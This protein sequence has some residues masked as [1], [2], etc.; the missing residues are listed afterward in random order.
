LL[1][2]RKNV[3][4]ESVI[5]LLCGL[6]FLIFGQTFAYG[7]ACVWIGATGTRL[8]VLDIV[9]LIQSARD[10]GTILQ[11]FGLLV[12][13]YI[14]ASRTL[15]VDKRFRT[16]L[17]FS[18]VTALSIMLAFASSVVLIPV[19]KANLIAT[20][21][22]YLDT[23][24]PIADYYAGQYQN[25]TFFAING[26]NWD[27]Y[28]TSADSNVLLN[29]VLGNA[30]SGVVYVGTGAYSATVTVYNGT[31]LI[32]ARGATGI[33]ASIDTGATA[34]IEDQNAG[35]TRQYVSGS[36]IS[37]I[38]LSTG[39]VDMT[40]GNFT[41]Y[42]WSN[43][44]R[45]DTLAY[46]EQTASYIVFQDGSLT[47]MKNGTTGQIDAS[48]TVDID[49]I[50]W[51]LGN[52]TVGRT[53]QEKVL[54]KGNFELTLPSGNT[55]CIDVPSYTE[56][57]LQGSVK[58][59]NGVNKNLIGNKDVTSSNT[60]IY[61]HGGI[62]DGNRNY[63]TS[64]H[65]LYICFASNP[66]GY[67]EFAFLTIGDMTFINIKS[68]GIHIEAAD[69][70]SIL[71]ISIYNIV[72]KYIGNYGLYT[73]GVSDVNIVNMMPVEGEIGGVFIQYGGC[74]HMDECFING[75]I[76]FNAHTMFRLTNSFIDIDSNKHGID[77]AGLRNSQLSNVGIR[78][79]GDGAT[80]YDGIQLRDGAGYHATNN[81][82]T[83]LYIGRAGGTG[84]RRFNYGIEEVDANQDYNT[85]MGINGRDCVTASLRMLG[86]NSFTRGNIGYE[87]SGTA[88]VANNEW[89]PHGLAGTP[90]TVTI[91]P[92]AVTYGSPAVTFVVGVVARNSTMF[93]VGCY[94]TNGTAI[95][96]DAIVIDYYCEY[97]P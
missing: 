93:Q 96:T 57:E 92:R 75:G 44:N 52:L 2:S 86:A 59:A 38:N 42:W 79:T 5:A 69:D 94:W 36:L 35:F 20:T 78:V 76:V 46:P 24:L 71:Q 66:V 72:N 45:T 65:G 80:T 60:H 7:G 33:T 17:R 53:W 11:V 12:V 68:D 13:M 81:I 14:V 97:K 74:I 34:T 64:G 70:A 40:Y 31:R 43:Y 18:L 54:L 28:Y 21:T 56:I 30:S 22:Y 47:K 10:V 61:I 29:N 58:L 4:F 8:Q 23:P 62:W 48:S 84:T 16:K 37:V 95:T 39:L 88:T 63:Q 67:G 15:T 25:N 55:N 89:V 6:L 90:T 82:F 27:M 85:Y 87:N 50:N 51:A 49:V 1:F 3:S 26:T 91:T 83:N 9:S 41:Q 32:I 19:G 77:G 73:S